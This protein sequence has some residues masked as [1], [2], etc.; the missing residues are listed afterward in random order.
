MTFFDDKKLCERFAE[1]SYKF[2]MEIGHNWEDE[3]A[4][5]LVEAYD[6]LFGFIEQWHSQYSPVQLKLQFD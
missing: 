2:V 6:K 4:K 5:H 3:S 1:N